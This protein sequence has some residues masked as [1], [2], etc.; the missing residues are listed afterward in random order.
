MQFWPLPN[1]PK[2]WA[3]TML[4]GWRAADGGI[5][6]PVRVKPRT[7]FNRLDGQRAGVL[8]MSV[9]AIPA[10]GAANAAVVAILAE[11]LNRPKACVTLVKGHK[12]RDK[13][14][15]VSGVTGEIIL[16]RLIHPDE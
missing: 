14:V 8:Q 3:S 1:G 11:V 13:S 15:L 5:V 9:R 2:S 6:L 4:A 16:Q 7:T 10:D 12:S